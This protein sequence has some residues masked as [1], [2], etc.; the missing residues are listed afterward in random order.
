LEEKDLSPALTIGL[1]VVQEILK[2]KQII[3][4]FNLLGELQVEKCNQEITLPI[5]LKELSQFDLMKCL[6][7]KGLKDEKI[8]E[9]LEK[10]S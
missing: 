9:V 6:Y 10:I 4:G 1:I 7:E 3:I 5:E 2:D 8:I